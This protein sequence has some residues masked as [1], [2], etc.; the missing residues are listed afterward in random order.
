[1][2]SPVHFLLCNLLVSALL[3]VLLLVRR[4]NTRHLSIPARYRL[5]QL[6][7]AALFL[8]FFPWKRL[9]VQEFLFRI[10]ELL[11]GG[12][13]SAALPAASG[14]AA[15]ASASGTAIRDLSTAA[16]DSGWQLST[17]LWV[18]WIIGMAAAAFYFICTLVHIHRIRKEAFLVTAAA[19]PELHRQF[20]SCVKELSIRQKV[21]LYTSCGI[22]NPVSCGWLRPYIIIPQD[23]DI[24]SSEEELR[25]IFLH[26]LQ[27]CKH[28]DALLNLLICVL[29]T[30]Y[31]FNPL[32][33]YGFRQ[34]RKDREMACDH[35]VIG[36]IGVRDRMRYGLT[37]LRFA[38]H[39]RSGVFASPLSGISS[40]GS[41]TRQRIVEITEYR[42][43]SA[44]QRLKS[45]GIFALIFLLLLGTSPLLS[46]Y[47]SGAPAPHLSDGEWQ[48]VDVS[49]SFGKK[50]GSF[51]LYDMSTGGY[52][53][54]NKEKSEERVAPASTFKIYSGLFALEEGVI[55]A[56][57]SAQKWDGS[58]QPFA[59]WMQDQTLASAM[60]NSVNWY[61]QNLDQETGLASL[62]SYYSRI[63]YG[64]CDLSG[65][66]RN[67]WTTSLAISPLEQVQLLSG[68]LDNRWDF[69]PENIQAVKD[70]LLI[71]E[72]SVSGGSL[73]GKTGSIGGIGTSAG[74]SKTTGS[75]TS[76]AGGKTTG[77]G[78]SADSDA[79]ANNTSADG[80]S[81]QMG[82][83]VGFLETDEST[84]CFAVNLQGEGC[85]GSAAAD[86]AVDALSGLVP[87]LA[88]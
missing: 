48:A 52:Y 6:F 12:K 26:E 25:F 39:A 17:V 75:S 18:I 62:S 74:S 1:M 81:Q 87:S 60:E 14:S 27:H 76:A 30:L 78:T 13:T 43:S 15:Q 7:T 70:S 47:A 40:D 3:G 51:V 32:I 37:I 8:P 84:Y 71:A 16:A 77:S 9:S 49:E 11:A 33:W 83:F 63:S 21:A 19:E 2:I 50:E 56:E 73:Y 24:V 69:D 80:S 20:V 53:I 85:D 35:A 34:F 44:V 23:L 54:Y 68:L 65:G 36:R 88:R 46:A 31:W 59:Q 22:Q 66:V 29:E 41:T 10:Q 61:F 38:Q 42:P 4:L 45:A 72:D 67:Y 5:W 28:R 58:P 82:W 86:V 79:T 55:T 57:D 64:N